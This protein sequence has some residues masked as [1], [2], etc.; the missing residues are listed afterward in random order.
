MKKKLKTKLIRIAI[1]IA[2]I[3]ALAEFQKYMK[4]R[5]GTCTDGTCKTPS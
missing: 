4:N 5:C 3:I 1:M 2:I